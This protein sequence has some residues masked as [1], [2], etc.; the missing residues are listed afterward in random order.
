MTQVNPFYKDLPANTT[1][2]VIIVLFVLAG[3]AIQFF[4]DRRFL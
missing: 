3:F 4:I 1:I 2:M